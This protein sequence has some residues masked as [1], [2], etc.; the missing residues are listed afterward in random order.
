MSIS[1]FAVDGL[2]W[3]KVAA[4]GAQHL[5]EWWI[6]HAPP[7]FG[8]GAALLLTDARGTVRK[9]IRLIQGQRGALEEATAVAKTFGAYAG[10]LAEVLSTGSKNG[11]TPDVVLVGRRHLDRA[12]LLK[13]GIIIATIHTGGWE[14][15][16]PL[17]AGYRKCELVMVMQGERDER[18]REIQDR[19]RRASGL[20]VVHVGEDPLSSLPLLRHLREESTVALQVDRVSPG[21]RSI[22]VQ[23]L[24]GPFKMPVGPLRL[25]QVSG[26]PL[27]PIFSA[28]TG[29]RR[30]IVQA[31][32][33][34]V[35]GR[36]AQDA[37][38]ERAGQKI[39]D[40]ISEFLKE[41][42][43]QWFRFKE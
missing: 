16:G 22:E 11:G 32:A 2:F 41:H 39:A 36:R 24:S 35:I 37:D 18:A 34:I 12:V 3:R 19:A 15:V 43:T 40:A 7:L 29:Y 25:A 30:Y 27:V 33:P 5:P 6:K 20:S 1:P 8:A 14:L 42:P 31:H 10:C 26:A 4:L 21:M 17:L 9:N 28:R 13:K 38:L 23:L